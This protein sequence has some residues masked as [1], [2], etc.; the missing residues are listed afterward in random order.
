M[1]AEVG[2]ELA[3]LGA[4][5]GGSVRF[6]EV[7]EHDGQIWVA[8]R[9]S[10]GGSAPR[11]GYRL[12]DVYDAGPETLVEAFH[13]FVPC[14][15]SRAWLTWLSSS[16]LVLGLCR[17]QLPANVPRP[18]LRAFRRRAEPY[19]ADRFGR[20]RSDT[21]CFHVLFDLEGAVHAASPGVPLSAL[22]ACV[23]LVALSP[24]S[25]V[26][27][28]DVVPGFRVLVDRLHAGQEHRILAR[29]ETLPARRLP[30]LAALTPS[31]AAVCRLV[32]DGTPVPAAAGILGRS[33]ETLRT[34]LRKAY[35]RLG[36]G[37]RLELV[38][39]ARE[40]DAFA[41]AA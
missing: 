14:D 9:W 7:V 34:H 20:V 8:R 18:D 2:E 15:G 27:L 41:P 16:D 25:G 3:R 6:D 31:Q 30:A 36:I 39:L 19:F 10:S 12:A 13:G 35:R 32:A 1:E 4:R 22:N 40:L 11:G 21:S 17:I 28:L 5:I 24:P 38:D 26:P 29:F 33:P 23:G 37:S